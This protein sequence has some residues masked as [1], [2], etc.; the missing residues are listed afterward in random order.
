[1]EQ[2]ARTKQMEKCLDNVSVAVM[3][4]LEA[5]DKYVDAQEASAKLGEYYGGEEC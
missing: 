4:F 5:L 1:M 2:L 3:E